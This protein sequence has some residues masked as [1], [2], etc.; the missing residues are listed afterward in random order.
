MKF[1]LLAL[2]TIV[3]EFISCIFGG[4]VFT[5]LYGWFL[6]Q[7]FDLPTIS[8]PLA[9]GIAYTISFLTSR[10][11]QQEAEDE[12]PYSDKLVYSFSYSMSKSLI[13]LAVG[14]VTQLFL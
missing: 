13:F 9:I 11:S 1:L 2:L 14:Y 3:V 5:K 10:V 4:F 8:L 12:K 6:Q 7:T